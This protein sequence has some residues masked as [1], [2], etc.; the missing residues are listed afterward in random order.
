MQPQ[1]DVSLL[2]P[3]SRFKD[4]DERVKRLSEEDRGELERQAEEICREYSI[5]LKYIEITE[6]GLEHLSFGTG[7]LD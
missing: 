3:Y 5:D 7:I 1:F 6:N 2:F 4:Y